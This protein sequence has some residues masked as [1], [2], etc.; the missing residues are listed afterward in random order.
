[1]PELTGC[2]RRIDRLRTAVRRTA[3]SYRE[4]LGSP[5]ALA[6]FVAAAPGRVGIAMTSLGIVW[7][8]HW[9]TGSFGAAG[10]VTGGFAIAEACMGPQVARL[11]DRFG[12]TRVLPPCLVAH[13]VAVVALG[14][15]AAAGAPLPLLIPLGIL[16]GSFIPQTGALTT[17]RWT[18]LLDGSP[19]LS[20]AFALESVSN[21]V[22]YVV[23]PALVGAIGTFAHPVATTLV[24]GGLVVGAGFAL[25]LQPATAP[26]P[27]RLSAAAS[28]RPAT[29]L[30]RPFA[31]LVG[32]NLGLG[33]FFGSTQVAV[34]AFAIERGQPA[35]AGVV[36][37]VSS[38]ASLLAGALYGLRRWRTAAQKQI[39]VTLLLIATGCVLLLAAGTVQF[40]VVALAVAGLG[41]AP[42]LILLTLLIEARVG[43]S[44]LTQAFTWQNSASAAGIALGAASAGH[45]ADALGN[46]WAF[47]VAVGAMALT[48]GAAWSL[49]TSPEGGTQR[50]SKRIS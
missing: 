36:L 17:S 39:R 29:L 22:A 47:A 28:G 46:R 9:R 5:G 7:L 25:A 3:D 10:V 15:A 30:Q 23:G 34:T 24:A 41:I 38:L 37:G 45:L 1:M 4:P 26:P 43:R 14:A 50:R 49:D 44:V 19:A 16:V 2:G 18:W 21:G 31:V 40:L 27:T 12:Q 35:A 42:T 6:F 32:A 48:T 20:S 8:V 11:V 13:G 33:L